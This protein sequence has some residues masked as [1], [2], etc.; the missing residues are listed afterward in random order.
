M[1]FCLLTLK[2]V[3]K[4]PHHIQRHL[5]G[6]RF[7]KAYEYWLDCQEKGIK[8]VPICK[9]RFVN[10]EQADEVEEDGLDDSETEEMFDMLAMEEDLETISNGPDE[11]NNNGQ[12]NECDDSE[13]LEKNND[14]QNSAEDSA[15]IE[16]DTR[17]EGVKRKLDPK[18]N[19]NFF[20]VFSFVFSNAN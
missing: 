2:H 12:N 10:E 5:N 18:V 14:T 3:N 15:D 17:A 11:N 9:Q 8:F 19:L 7:Q 6:R 4:Q 20:K 1:L 13:D 16:E